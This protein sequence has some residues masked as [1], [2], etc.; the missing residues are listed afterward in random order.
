MKDSERIES[1]K[2]DIE[3]M[4]LKSSSQKERGLQ[5]LAVL[6]MVGGVITAFSAYFSSTH[7]DDFRDQNELIILAIA[8][9]TLVLIGAVMFVRYSMAKFLRFWLLRQFYE[10]QDHIDRIV[11]AMGNGGDPAPGPAGDET[12]DTSTA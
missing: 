1:F 9:L 4:K 5:L 3:D 8:S 12:S 10:G 7:Q 2:T 11:H 6:L